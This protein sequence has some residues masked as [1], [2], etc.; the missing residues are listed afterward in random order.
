MIYINFEIWLFLTEWL[1]HTVIYNSKFAAN[2][3]GTYRGS[4]LR[5][6]DFALVGN[7]ALIGDQFGAFATFEAFGVVPSALGTVACALNW[8]VAHA[9]EF[10]A[11]TNNV[12]YS[13]P[14]QTTLVD[15]RH[16]IREWLN[17][18]VFLQTL[19]TGFCIRKISTIM[20]DFEV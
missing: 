14:V 6:K 8:S 11:C 16:Y 20:G 3:V 10:L 7:K 1:P 9:A 4:T 13:L 2:A 15:F 5:V 18:L 17:V 12:R 19:E